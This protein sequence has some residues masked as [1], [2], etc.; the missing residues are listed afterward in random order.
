MKDRAAP[1]PGDAQCWRCYYGPWEGA[2]LSADSF[3]QEEIADWEE[4]LT[5]QVLRARADGNDDVHI[6]Q[7]LRSNPG[8]DYADFFEYL[9]GEF[10]RCRPPSLPQPD[11]V[12]WQE[13]DRD[14]VRRLATEKLARRLPA[15][16][17]QAAGRDAA[18]IF[19]PLSRRHRLRPGDLTPPQEPWL[20][21]LLTRS[22]RG[23]AAG[24]NPGAKV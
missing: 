5:G 12:P 17:R 20:A 7:F 14:V 18:L 6:E 19:N 13:L 21:R 8:T 4:F 22:G 3:T 9:S 16:V 10:Y 23:R 11:E 15:N 2:E 1:H 24:P